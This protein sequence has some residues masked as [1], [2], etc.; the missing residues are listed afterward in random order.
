MLDI[1]ASDAR[2]RANTEAAKRQASGQRGTGKVKAQVAGSGF[3]VGKGTAADLE[4]VPEF[5]ANLD[6]AAIRENGRRESLGYE[7]QAEFKRNEADA[8][9]PWAN[10]SMTAIG[11]AARAGEYWYNRRN[12]PKV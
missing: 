3:S 12:P 6:A 9:T 2:N 4:S 11:G 10:A 8:E 1:Q 5:I 7:T